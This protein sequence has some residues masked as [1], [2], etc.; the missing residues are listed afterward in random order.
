MELQRAGGLARRGRRRRAGGR[1]ERA[2]RTPWRAGSGASSPSSSRAR[3]RKD[4]RRARRIHPAAC[5]GS[6]DVEAGGELRDPGE[7]VRAGREHGAAQPL[8]AALEV[9]RRAVALERAGRRQDQVGPAAGEL[10]E[11]R[12]HDDMLGLLGERAHV[13]GRPRRRRPRR[14]AARSAPGS[15]RR[16]R[17][18]PPSR[19]RRRARSASAG[20]WNAPQPGL[21]SKPSSCASSARRA[22]PPPPGP[23]RRGSRARR[24]AASCR[25]RCAARRARAQARQRRRATRGTAPLG[26]ADDD[27]GSAPAGL[28]DPE[29]DDR[30]ALDDG[31]VTDDDDDLGLG[32]RAQRQAERL[33]RVGR[34]LGQHRGVRAEASSRSSRPS[35]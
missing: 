15:P 21:S 32:D 27:L 28:L 1:S 5:G 9:H 4:A 14:R 19:A 13:R 30:R 33:E 7:L 6:V 25:A 22:P 11:H 23:T 3:S 10:V 16:R 31:V 34:R 26:R 20:R 18:R 2:A 35:A 17:R 24:R 29:V 8:H 12:E